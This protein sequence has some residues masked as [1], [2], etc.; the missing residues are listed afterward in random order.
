MVSEMTSRMSVA[1]MWFRSGTVYT[2]LAP[3]TRPIFWGYVFVV[4]E[5]NGEIVFWL[6]GGDRAGVERKGEFGERVSLC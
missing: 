2:A 4:V 3:A 6:H 1:A 5:E